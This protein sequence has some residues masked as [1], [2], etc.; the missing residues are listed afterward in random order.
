M[1]ED[2]GGPGESLYWGVFSNSFPKALQLEIKLCYVGE[3]VLHKVRNMGVPIGV[4][5]FRVYEQT[6]T[7][8]MIY[9][10]VGGKTIP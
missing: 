10:A 3:R 6:E 2:S 4:Y 1:T 8:F 5:I 7:C 9:F